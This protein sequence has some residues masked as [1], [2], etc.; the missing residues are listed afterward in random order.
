MR[1]LTSTMVALLATP[2]LAQD[3][4]AVNSTAT[5]ENERDLTE[6]VRRNISSFRTL[7]WRIPT[8]GWSARRRAS[9]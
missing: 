9:T 5:T 6:T 3:T 1:L 7:D 4:A 2:A 8:C